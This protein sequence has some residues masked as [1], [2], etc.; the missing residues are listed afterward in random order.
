MTV[1]RYEGRGRGDDDRPVCPGCLRRGG[2]WC[3]VCRSAGVARDEQKRP[4]RESL[5]MS[6]NAVI[7]IVESDRSLL[8]LAWN[9]TWNVAAA[10][11]VLLDRRLGRRR[12][13]RR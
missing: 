9:L 1:T 4:E 12:R 10:A 7:E 6:S 5:G 8:W 3:D 11:V 2:F 13:S